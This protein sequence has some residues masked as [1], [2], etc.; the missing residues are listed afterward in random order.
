MICFMTP[1]GRVHGKLERVAASLKSPTIFKHFSVG[2][3]GFLVHRL[4]ADFVFPIGILICFFY[5]NRLTIDIFLFP[6]VGRTKCDR[7]NIVVDDGSRRGKQQT[8]GGQIENRNFMLLVKKLRF[9]FNIRGGG[10]LHPGSLAVP[11][12][13]FFFQAL[14]LFSKSDGN[15]HEKTNF[16]LSGYPSG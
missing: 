4:G 3:D 14:K 7:Q 15:T 12:F 13:L 6:V 10:N 16:V 8:V 9:S 2:A 5:A 1:R 11:S